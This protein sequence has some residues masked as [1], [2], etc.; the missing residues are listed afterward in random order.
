M[1]TID[2]TTV[3]DL[4][5][6]AW[7]REARAAG[8][9]VILEGRNGDF[10]F[11]VVDGLLELTASGQLLDIVRAGDVIGEMSLIDG[12]PR[13]AS[14]VVVEDAVLIAIDRPNFL[15]LVSAHPDFALY[16][17]RSLANRIRRM[18]DVIVKA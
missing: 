3:L 2:R 1:T 18:N 9:H 7:A 5:D 10:M 14:A 11:L 6:D 16:V 15:R 17:M 4:F 8:D 12:E 13:S